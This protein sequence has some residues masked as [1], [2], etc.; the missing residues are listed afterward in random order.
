MD[1]EGYISITGRIKD[2]IIRGGENIHP[3]EIENCLLGHPQVE[4]VSVVGMPDER[5]GEVVAAFIVRR[6][7]NTTGGTGL[8]KTAFAEEVRAWVKNRLSHHLGKFSLLLL[9]FSHVEANGR[10]KSQYLNTYFSWIR[11]RKLRAV[12]FRNSS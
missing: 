5:Y 10:V 6:Q 9:L 11:T 8:D 2:L 7:Q 1:P 3:L 12:R 4:D